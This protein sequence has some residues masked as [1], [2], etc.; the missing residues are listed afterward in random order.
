MDK[1]E[2][3]RLTDIAYRLATGG[4]TTEVMDKK[5]FESCDIS[6]YVWQ[7]LEYYPESEYLDAITCLAD[8][9]L[10]ALKRE[11]KKKIKKD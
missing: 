10:Q 2:E 9:I 5:Q 3:K 1:K 11:S 6:D 4:L 7:P 8:D